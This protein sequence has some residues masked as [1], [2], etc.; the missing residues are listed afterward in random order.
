MSPSG[1]FQPSLMAA[2]IYR[3]GIEHRVVY[4]PAGT[5]YSSRHES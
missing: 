2:P 1:E 5:W 4:L 3:P